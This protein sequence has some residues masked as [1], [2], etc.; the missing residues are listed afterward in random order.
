MFGLLLL[1]ILIYYSQRMFQAFRYKDLLVSAVLALVIVLSHYGTFGAMM[2]YG[3]AAFLSFALV[4]RLTR[5]TLLTA[6]GLS[7]SASVALVLIYFLD[8]QRFQRLFP[9][10][11]GIPRRLTGGGAVQGQR[12]FYGESDLT[13]RNPCLLLRTVPRLPCM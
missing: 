12:T 6:F 2:L 10:S 9:L 5:Q 3:V 8:L 11:E 7:I 13:D 1:A 4:H